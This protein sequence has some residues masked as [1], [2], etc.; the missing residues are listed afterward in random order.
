[1]EKTDYTY[2]L[3]IRRKII[4]DAQKNHR[5]QNLRKKL[6]VKSMAL[7]VSLG[8]A[9]DRAPDLYS[10]KPGFKSDLLTV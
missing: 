5:R 6:A 10:G 1:M 2:L 8:G 3:H 7:D 9:V 4:F